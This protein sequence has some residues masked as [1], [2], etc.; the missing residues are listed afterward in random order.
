MRPAGEAAVLSPLVRRIVAPNPSAMTGDGTNTY[1]V[2]TGDVAVIDPGPDDAGHLE[3]IVR[4]VGR[5]RVRWVLLTHTHSDHAPGAPALARRTGAVL[6]AIW[7]RNPAVVLDR[8][9]ADGE[10]LSGAE[11][12]LQAVHTPGHASN[13]LCFWL[14]EERAVF[15]GDLVMSGSTIVIVPPDGDMA[16]YLHS[17]DRVRQMH[18]ARIYPGH[19]DLMEDPAATIGEYIKHRLLREQ[20]VL[21]GLRTGPRRIA[22]LVPVIYTGLPESLHRMAAMS[23]FAH[24]LKLKAEGKVT[25]ADEESEWSW[26]ACR[27]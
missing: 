23:I 3:A 24:L 4:A 1:L 25:G 22:E 13:H 7:S 17:L 26:N 19:G 11:F 6:L 15:A 18:P 27:T 21:D 9:L 14:A 16:A 2:G 20:Q 10:A 5:G 8:T 12:T